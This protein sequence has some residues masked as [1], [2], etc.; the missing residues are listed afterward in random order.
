MFEATRTFAELA[1]RQ[2]GK[3]PRKGRRGKGGETR[4]A[5]SGSQADCA[6]QRRRDSD[7]TQ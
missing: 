2:G 5:F 4:I 7:W 1:G 3:K 6:P